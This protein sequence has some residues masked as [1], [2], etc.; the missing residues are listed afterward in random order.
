MLFSAG[1]GTGLLFSAVW[2]PLYHWFFPESGQGG[3]LESIDRSFQ[4]TFLHWGFAG[5]A[6][7][8]FMGLAVACLSFRK[9]LPLR[10]SSLLHSLLK[11]KTN[12]VIG[13]SI[14][15]L[16]S[17]AILCGVATTLG[18][19]TL[20]INSGLKEMLNIPFSGLTQALIIIAI[21]FIAT[22]SLL[23][24]LNRGIRRLSE[25]NILLCLLLMVFV[26]CF[27]PTV[28]LL[29]SFVE[30]FGAYL[31]NSFASITQVESLGSVEWRSQWTVFY[32][33]WWIAWSPFVGIFIARISEGRTIRQFVFGALLFPLF[34]PVCGSLFLEAQLSMNIL[35]TQ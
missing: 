22:C 12:G 35:K 29:N 14:D 23:S 5:W 2:E 3:S 30:Y 25:L 16:A 28:K 6:V 4:I 9:G 21:T 11:G 26:F 31:Q 7:Y 27:G 8:T 17:T 13:I 32:W 19:G 10:V 33:A 18:R 20:Q 24:G 34:Y 15:I 1:M